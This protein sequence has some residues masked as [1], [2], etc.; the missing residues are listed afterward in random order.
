M[1]S[2]RLVRAEITRGS[3]TSVSVRYVP[4]EIFG[5]WSYLMTSKHG[6]AVRAHQASLWIDAEE[7]PDIRASE[8]RFDEV[9]EVTLFVYSND[10]GMFSRVTR[11]F[12]TQ[13]YTTLR[14]IFLRHYAQHTADESMEP[15]IRERP[16]VWIRRNGVT[17]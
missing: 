11:Y 4:M 10:E 13:E 1:P 15:Q 17:V 3:E 2:Q 12:P 9:T 8:T 6:F 5:L 7:S 14:D 16:G